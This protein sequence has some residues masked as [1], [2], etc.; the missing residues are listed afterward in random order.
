MC[1]GLAARFECPG[2]YTDDSKGVELLLNL[3]KEQGCQSVCFIGGSDRFFPS[4][5]TSGCTKIAAV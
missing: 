1:G 3:L 2:I 5:S 4:Y